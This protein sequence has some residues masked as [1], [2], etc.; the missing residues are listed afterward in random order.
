MQT[1]SSGTRVKRGSGVA[2]AL[3]ATLAPAIAHAGTNGAVQPP[4]ARAPHTAVQAVGA[5]AASFQPTDHA[6]DAA[7]LET[8]PATDE[9]QHKGLSL[10][11]SAGIFGVLYG[12]TYMA[13]YLRSDESPDFHLHDEGWFAV[14]TYAG[15]ADKIGHA[16]A[17][18][19]LVRGVSSILEWGGWQKK[20]ALATA[21]GSTMA[22]FLMSE[23]KDGYHENYGFSWGDVVMNLTGTGLGVLMELSPEVDRRFDFR[24]EYWPSKPFRDAIADRGPFNSPEDYSGQRFFL[25]YH[26]SSIET[27]RESDYFGWSEYMDLAV[28]FH[29]NHYKPEDTDSGDHEQELFL[30]V[31]L[32]LQTVID[33]AF[34]PP[35]SSLRK[36]GTGTRALRFTAEI[37]QLPYTLIDVG[38]VS[39]SIPDPQPAQASSTV[40]P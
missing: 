30:G 36:S 4:P 31:S 11:I 13:W 40:T 29:A 38:G 5:H 10:G 16:W 14:D 25:A 8:L 15:G 6:E 1:T 9:E 18:Y 2:G 35:P 21:T 22:F 3:L 7:L 17:N 37:V 12:Y 34:A 33:K 27:L 24:V 19:A 32:N 26:L 20:M 28:G 39:R 23:I